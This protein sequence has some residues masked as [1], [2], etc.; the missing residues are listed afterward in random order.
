VPYDCFLSYASL[1]VALAEDL[2]RRLVAA[3]F[4]VW[5]DKARLEPGFDWHREIEGGCENSRVALPVLTPRWKLSDWT[6]FETYG[7]E[8]VVPLIF[9][10]EWSAVATPP[11][12]RFQAERLE[13]GAQAFNWERLLTSLRRSLAQPMPRKTTRV[14]HLHYLPNPYFVGREKEMVRIHEELHR[15]PRGL[16]TEGR[17]RVI[18]AL[19]GVGKTTLA[20]H[21]AEKFWRCYTQIFWVDCRLGLT[22]EF[23][24]LYDL[25]FAERA[26]AGLQDAQKAEAALR[27]L[28][29][30]ETRLLIL[31]NADDEASVMAWIPKT[32]G[33][34]TLIT[35]RYGGWS[36]AIK[37]LYL[38]VLDRIA[39]V[40]FLQVRVGRTVTA[41]ELK[42]CGELADKMG[43]LPLAMEQAAAYVEQQG[44]AYGFRDYLAEFDRSA[45]ELLA[46]GALG[47]TEYPDS[48]ITTWRP[49]VAKLKPEARVSLQLAAC[50]AE[51]PIPI[52]MFTKSA[53]VIRTRAGARP[54]GDEPA[55][56]AEEFAI[57]SAIGSLK[58]YSLVNSD[59]KNFALHPLLRK[60]EQ[61]SAAAAGED[62]RLQALDLFLAF[63]PESADL[64]H[65]WS[66]W[67]PLFR[68]G[69]LLNETVGDAPPAKR[70]Q[71]LDALARYSFGKAQFEDSLA[72]EKQAWSIAES[73]FGADSSELADRLINYGESLR[74]FG[75][76]EEAEVLFRRALAWREQHSGHDSLD[77]ATCL[78][79][80]GLL[81]RVVG[82]EA[83]AETNLR[84][85]IAICER[86]QITSERT[87]VKLLLNLFMVVVSGNLEEARGLVQR[88]LEIS[89]K[90][91]G[92][93]DQ[94]T[95]HSEALVGV[96]ANNSKD[97]AAAEEMMRRGVNRQ[98]RLFGEEHPDSRQAMLGL[99]ILLYNRGKYVEAFEW[100]NKVAEA[101]RSWHQE[102]SAEAIDNECAAAELL[103][104]VGRFEEALRL[105]R[106]AMEKSEKVLGPEDPLTAKCGAAV[107]AAMAN[108]GQIVEADALFERVEKGLGKLPHDR[109][110]TVLQTMRES[111]LNMFLAG[112]YARTERLLRTLIRYDFEAAS[113]YCHLARVLLMQDRDQE[114][115]EA[116]KA[117]WEHIARA[118][119]YVVPRLYYMEMLFAMLDRAEW[120]PILAV[121][122]KALAAA[123]S[124]SEWKLANVLDHLAPR[125]DKNDIPFLRAL[126]AGLGDVEALPKLETYEVWRR[127]EALEARP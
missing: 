125:L 118:R 18:T 103:L 49:T 124:H 23:A 25:L 75:K 121:L 20:R 111:A 41:D 83:E 93:D 72:Y 40:E 63:A 44:E 17:V 65:T 91:F 33:C 3:E 68:H 21:Y 73:A 37:M 95:A 119:P 34:H 43:C 116:V 105:G 9:E 47:S 15:N 79:Y 114:A 101:Q 32:G 28:S 99:A 60:V 117:A 46:A 64:P 97:Y 52:Q 10:G 86:R 59:G 115:A 14:T 74:A 90:E 82:R 13:I 127:A 76:C 45:A 84:E 6:R 110:Q 54:E 122:R 102:Q 109:A 81:L 104:R 42:A 24:Q 61:M 50:L 70:I 71:L 35:S 31:D 126:L 38:F 94:L 29:G 89:E 66:T 53:H 123:E 4:T 77:T 100:R 108:L 107:A 51:A 56:D 87:F 55:T 22:A 36:S 92:Q 58:M 98:V 120:Q 19:G 30:P 7:V 112:D 88:A 106:K 85:G 2:Y 12:E 67:T 57:N 1:D 27:A 39:A 48:V 16:L 96:V 26:V 11:L 80:L 8:T 5:F 69:A 62:Y 78:N 113:N